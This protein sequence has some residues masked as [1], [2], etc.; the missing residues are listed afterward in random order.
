MAV[1]HLD[2]TGSGG[3][4][5]E[6]EEMIVAVMCEVEALAILGWQRKV[7]TRSGSDSKRMVR[8]GGIRRD[9]SA[10]KQG[11]GLG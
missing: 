6:V 7:K 3:C 5:F 4:K 8:P 2:V 9:D 10:G 1:A 11:L